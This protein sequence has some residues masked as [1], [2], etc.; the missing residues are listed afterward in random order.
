MGRPRNSRPQLT[1]DSLGGT[2]ETRYLADGPCAFG[3]PGAGP[4]PGLVTPTWHL[5]LLPPRQH[6]RRPLRIYTL[7]SPERLLEHTARSL[8]AVADTRECSCHRH[9]P[10]PR[11][12][13]NQG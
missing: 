3:I 13:S 5:G 11:S 8:H 4:S 7:R 1:R 6:A 12:L 9:V 10:D 2:R